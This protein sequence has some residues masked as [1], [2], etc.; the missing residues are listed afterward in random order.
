MREAAARSNYGTGDS[1]Y[2]T[3]SA[4]GVSQRYSSCIR[5]TDENGKEVII[6]TINAGTVTVDLDK[7]NFDPLE[8]T[9]SSA[10]NI[11]YYPRFY[12][13][14]TGMGEYNE[15]YGEFLFT[16]NTQDKSDKVRLEISPCGGLFKNQWSANIS[17]CRNYVDISVDTS[18]AEGGL[19]ELTVYGIGRN[20]SN[21][22]SIYSVTDSVNLGDISFKGY[23]GSGFTV[24]SISAESHVMNNCAYLGN[25]TIDESSVIGGSVQIYGAYATNNAANKPAK[26]DSIMFGW[27]DG[28]KLPSGLDNEKFKAILG[29]LDKS[30]C[31]GQIN[32]SGTVK[33]SIYVRPVFSYLS[34]SYI[35][36]FKNIINNGTVNITNLTVSNLVR[37]LALSDALLSF[38]ENNAPITVD[39]V[40]VNIQ[41]NSKY[42]FI[43]GCAPGERNVNNAPI[44]VSHCL[45]TSDVRSYSR[46][47]VSGIARTDAKVSHCENRGDI[48][49][50]ECTSATVLGKDYKA[51]EVGGSEVYT[52]EFFVSGIGGTNADNCINFGD[53][54][55]SGALQYRAGGICDVVYSTAVSDC[56][57]Y[58]NVT[59]TDSGGRAYVGGIA[60]CLV[61]G[62]AT[63]SVKE[64]YNFGKVSIINPNSYI[65][66]KISPIIYLG[67]ICGYADGSGGVSECVNFGE[68]I[69]NNEKGE[70]TSGGYDNT[71]KMHS[72]F[73][74]VLF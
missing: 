4:A 20:S 29:T 26:I 14:G 11:D 52:G 57:N 37:V 22:K 21:G 9:P 68:V 36:Y 50:K 51:T 7:N 6:P 2:K 23:L 35:E 15:N 38:S 34:A 12:M 41:S 58:G 49:V 39:N 27:Y 3:I 24:Y 43:T 64:C 1:L 10:T 60:A 25:I 47:V 18:A 53:I 45:S 66:F 40:L 62:K 32:I 56:Y 46:V 63:R 5:E 48:T 17:N 54:S 61:D 33:G 67:G 73:I 13:M 31:Y 19:R 71:G 59:C 28:C 16:Q 69:Y 42:V 70:N 8:N 44:T 74:F 65:K 55:V 30:K 72:P